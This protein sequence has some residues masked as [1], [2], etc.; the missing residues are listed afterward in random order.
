MNRKSARILILLVAL[1]LVTFVL[2]NLFGRSEDRHAEGI[3]VTWSYDTVCSGGDPDTCAS[4]RSQALL[5]CL[6]IVLLSAA[7][8]VFNERR[9]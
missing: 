6:G 4:W 8:S 3:S 7:A 5:Q 1:A 2:A 9:R